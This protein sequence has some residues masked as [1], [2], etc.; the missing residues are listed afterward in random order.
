[1]NRYYIVR[2]RLIHKDFAII[3]VY[4]PNEIASKYM[5]QKLTKLKGEIDKSVA[6]IF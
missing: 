2:K 6:A 1:M 3:N 5:K 4:A